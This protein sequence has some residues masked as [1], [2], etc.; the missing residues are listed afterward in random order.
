MARTTFWNNESFS[1]LVDAIKTN[2]AATQK[3]DSYASNL[4]VTMN[5]NKDKKLPGIKSEAMFDWGRRTFVPP[6]PQSQKSIDA[7][8]DRWAAMYQQYGKEQ[9]AKTVPVSDSIE[10][11]RA[12]QFKKAALPKYRGIIKEMELGKSLY[13]N[14]GDKETA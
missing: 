1:R 6:T 11:A 4:A 12:D 14:W 2:R 9:V 3:L 10:K 5:A 13:K 8:A 7:S